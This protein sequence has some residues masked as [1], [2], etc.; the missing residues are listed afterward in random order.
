METF[1]ENLGMYTLIHCSL[2]SVYLFIHFMSVIIGRITVV[3]IF[4]FSMPFVFELEANVGLTG[5]HAEG[6]ARP[7][8]RS[9]AT[10]A[11]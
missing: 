2:L 9:I 11:L 3:A 10:A 1:C 8:S 5:R 6:P 4:W 7:V